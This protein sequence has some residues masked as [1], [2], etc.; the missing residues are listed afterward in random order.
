VAQIARV[1]NIEDVSNRRQNNGRHLYSGELKGLLRACSN[2]PRPS[3]IND[4]A[5][6]AIAWVTGARRAAIA[7]LDLSDYTPTGENEDDLMVGGK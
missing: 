6:I 2:D 4:A 1:A 3:R 7:N 5:M